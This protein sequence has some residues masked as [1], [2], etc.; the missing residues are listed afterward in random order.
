MTD[1]GRPSWKRWAVA[2]WAAVMIFNG[3]HQGLTSQTAVVRVLGA[4]TA[5]ACLVVEGAFVFEW[6]TARRLGAGAV[7]P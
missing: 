2:A 1:A 4:L 6:W 3:V 5:V 7:K